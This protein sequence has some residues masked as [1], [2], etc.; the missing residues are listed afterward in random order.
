MKPKLE[1][2]PKEVKNQKR[3]LVG[4]DRAMQGKKY[5]KKVPFDS[6]FKRTVARDFLTIKF[7]HESTSYG[8]RRHTLH[9]LQIRV[10]VH[11][12]VMSL[13]VLMLKPMPEL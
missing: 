8:P 11:T 3:F 1:G 7:C 13:T 6:P 5:A 4:L 10:L 12:S 2:D 9:L